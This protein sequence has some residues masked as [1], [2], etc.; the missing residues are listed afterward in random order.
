[1]KKLLR[2]TKK[3]LRGTKKPGYGAY[4]IQ[5]YRKTKT[6]G[7]MHIAQNRPPKA[8]RFC[9]KGRTVHL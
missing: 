7:Y 1:M 6:T 8:S 9:A 5:K 2:G 3:L 4:S